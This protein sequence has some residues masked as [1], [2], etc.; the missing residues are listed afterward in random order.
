MVFLNLVSILDQV[1]RYLG[2]PTEGTNPFYANA[3]ELVPWIN[4]AVQ[5]VGDE[6]MAIDQNYYYDT[7]TIDFVGGQEEY[8]LPA[9]MDRLI[10]VEDDERSPLRPITLNEFYRNEWM[11]VTSSSNNPYYYILLRDGLKFYPTPSGNETGA[12]TIHY[13]KRPGELISATASAGT[14]TTITL[15]SVITNGTLR[16]E[17]DYYKSMWFEI[18]SGVGSG[19]VRRAT[20]FNKTTRVLTFDRAFDTTPDATSVVAA[21]PELPRG[22]HEVAVYGALLRARVKRPDQDVVRWDYLNQRYGMLIEKI[23]RTMG[24]RQIQEPM[25]V[26]LTEDLD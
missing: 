26:G 22:H 21:C 5:E 10:R 7:T 11:S 24:E 12:I 20:A 15:P 3:T 25:Y 16:L 19:Q 18:V 1:R 9:R 2:E 6:L 4:Q 13:S 14:A 23:K 8:D 17:T